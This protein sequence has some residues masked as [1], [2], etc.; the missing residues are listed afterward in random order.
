MTWKVYALYFKE[1][2]LNKYLAER[3]IDRLKFILFTV[4]F[5]AC[6]NFTDLSN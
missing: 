1:I 4:I 3:G 5:G 6:S 2:I